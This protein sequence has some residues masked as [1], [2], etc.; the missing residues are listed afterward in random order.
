[1]KKRTYGLRFFPFVFLSK[2]SG[3]GRTAPRFFIYGEVRAPC[4]PLFPVFFPDCRYFFT[5]CRR[6]LEVKGMLYLCFSP[7]PVWRTRTRR[8]RSWS[9]RVGLAP[10]PPYDSPPFPAKGRVYFILGAGLLG[11]PPPLSLQ[12][13][14]FF[15]FFAGRVRD[16]TA[17]ALSPFFPPPCQT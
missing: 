1:V 16:D 10:P 9:G 11:C 12:T 15:S 14:Y 8:E 6:V 7:V 13:L 5:P 4:S 2:D 3:S 17:S